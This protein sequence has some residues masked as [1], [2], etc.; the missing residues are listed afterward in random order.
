MKRRIAATLVS[1]SNRNYRLY[2]FGQMVST[3]GTWAQKIAL[4]WLILELTGSSVVLGLTVALQALPI[5]L[6]SPWAGLLADRLDKH[7]I[8]IVT[9]CS[10]ILPAVAIGVVTA[11]GHATV[12]IVM[13]AAALTGIIEAFD[14]PPRQSFVIEM[15]GP[16]NMVNAITLNNII[17]NTGRLVGPA[18]AGLLIVTAGMSMTFFINA[19]SFVAVLLAL[20][21]MRKGDLNPSLRAARAKGQLIEGFRYVRDQPNLLG[22]LI[23]LTV[24]G[25][26]VWEWTVTIPILARDAFDGDAQVVGWMF[27][28]MGA[29]AILGALALAG[30]LRA[31]NTR[32]II[33]SLVFAILVGVVAVVPS[34]QASLALL[35]LLGSA[36]VAYRTITNSLAQMRAAPEMRGRTMSLFILATGGTSPF[37]GPL[38][39]WL[40]EVVGVRA[41]MLIGAGATIVAAIAVLLYLRSWNRANGEPVTHAIVVPVSEIAT[42]A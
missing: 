4:A 24:T 1:L 20:L 11:T 36:G 13:C 26:L 5:L 19:A 9:S 2:F 15:V 18:M 41:T 42:P 32:L 7:R 10:A 38:I 17:F 33:A 16:K 21:A 29:G 35:F 28:A 23:L 3:V 25:L 31:T 12:W 37:G 30:F 27:T 34:L 22:P 39:G 8:L 6:L 40:C 14:K